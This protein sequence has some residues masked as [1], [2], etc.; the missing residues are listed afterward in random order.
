M[1]LLSKDNCWLSQDTLGRPRAG[2]AARAWTRSERDVQAHDA[3]EPQ[4]VGAMDN[5]LPKKIVEGHDFAG[6]LLLEVN[7]FHLIG[8]LSLEIAQRQVVRRD[9]TE[10]ARR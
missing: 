10:S 8:E 4:R 7:V 1:A 2:D 3:H 5:S 6:D 9:R